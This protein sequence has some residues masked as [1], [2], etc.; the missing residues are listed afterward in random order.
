[1]LQLLKILLLLLQLQL[2]RTRLRLLLTAL[3]SRGWQQLLLRLLQQPESE[4]LNI[5]LLPLG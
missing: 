1:M 5:L 3:L 2:Q 4:F